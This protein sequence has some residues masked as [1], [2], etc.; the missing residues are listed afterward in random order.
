MLQKKLNNVDSNL[1]SYKYFTS[2]ASHKLQVGI[3][4]TY[5]N[6]K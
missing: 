5:E 3:S 4:I 1:A 2:A 6:Y